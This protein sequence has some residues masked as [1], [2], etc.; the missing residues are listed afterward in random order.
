MDGVQG[1]EPTIT[2]T[3]AE[4]D[5]KIILTIADNGHGIETDILHRLFDAF[6]TTKPAGKGTGLGLSLCY[7]ITQKHGGTIH[8]DSTVDVGTTV[9]ILFPLAPLTYEEV[10]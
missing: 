1:R 8:I 6:F 2:I 4:K 3:T 7:S 5:D 9:R 10:S